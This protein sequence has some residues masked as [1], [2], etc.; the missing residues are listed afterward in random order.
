MV[1]VPALWQLLERRI[2]SQVDARTARSSRRRFELGAELNR[3][4]GK[5]HRHRPRAHPLRPGAR[6]AR[7]QHPLPHLGRRRAAEGHAKLFAGLGF[8]LTEGYGLTEAAPV[9]TVAKPGSRRRARSARPI[10]GVTIK[11]DSPDEHGV[12]EVLARGPN[13]MAGYTDAEA[14]QAT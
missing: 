5:T 11:I 10:P 13:V 3:M 7:R 4:L 2:L 14:T 9:L 1:G 6:G 8:K 12:G